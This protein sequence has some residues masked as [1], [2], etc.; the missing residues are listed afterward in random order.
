MC[1]QS[2][3]DLWRGNSPLIKCIEES[4]F[5]KYPNYDIEAIR[6]NKDDLIKC[7]HSD[8][9]PTSEVACLNHCKGKYADMVGESKDP[10]LNL[11]NEYSTVSPVYIPPI[12]DNSWVWY[13]VTV[14]IVGVV[15]VMFFLAKRFT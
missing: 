12:H 5:G 9:I 7:C 1:A 8:C 2:T 3:P 6:D 10:L 14:G 4:G 11:Y 15:V 13:L